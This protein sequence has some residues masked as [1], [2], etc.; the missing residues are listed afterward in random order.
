MSDTVNTIQILI[1]RPKALIFV[2][3]SYVHTCMYGTVV[4]VPLKYNIAHAR[5]FCQVTSVCQADLLLYINGPY[6]HLFN[7]KF[8]FLS[9]LDAQH[10]TRDENNGHIIYIYIYIY[11]YIFKEK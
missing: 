10:N 4:M 5:E 9:L 11:I 8:H 6:K 2:C 7:S 3:K 1:K